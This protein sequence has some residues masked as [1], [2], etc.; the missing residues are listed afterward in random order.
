MTGKGGGRQALKK[1]ARIVTPDTIL[2]CYRDLVA[3]KSDDSGRRKPGR[4][5]TS[6]E[7]CELVVR[8]AR[9]KPTWGCNRIQGALAHLGHEL[10][11]GTIAN[12]LK[13]DGI[14]RVRSV[15]SSGPP[16][17]VFQQPTEPFTTSNLAAVLGRVLCREEADVSLA[18]VWAI[19]LVMLR[20][21][22]G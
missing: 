15:Y 4:P 18:L 17:V 13:E 14:E 20:G 16:V 12:L 1:I 3:R 22:L 19:F 11:R 10:S 21:V 2:A 7:V 9:E 5:R 6:T 8:I